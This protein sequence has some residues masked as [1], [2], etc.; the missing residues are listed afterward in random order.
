MAKVR[1]SRRSS[2]RNER[3]GLWF[4]TGSGASWKASSVPKNGMGR[5]QVKGVARKQRMLSNKRTKTA[6][7]RRTRNKD[8]SGKAAEL[9]PNPQLTSSTASLY[10][11]GQTENNTCSCSAVII[12]N[13]LNLFELQLIWNHGLDNPCISAEQHLQHKTFSLFHQQHKYSK[14]SHCICFWLC[15][16]I[17][18]IWLQKE[19]FP[20]KCN[21]C[22]G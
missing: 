21:S 8:Y 13:G 5:A 14:C 17:L 11:L 22:A 20:N 19:D 7:L 3:Q 2:R 12:F 15:A 10:L 6:W 9:W 18:K 4:T 16:S 1:L